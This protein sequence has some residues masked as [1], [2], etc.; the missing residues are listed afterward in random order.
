[1]FYLLKVSF[2]T[3][4]LLKLTFL[5]LNFK[6]SVFYPASYLRELMPRKEISMAKVKKPCYL[7]THFFWRLQVCD[8]HY[9][10]H[11]PWFSSMLSSSWVLKSYTVIIN[12]KTEMTRLFETKRACSDRSIWIF[13]NSAASWWPWRVKSWM[14]H[15]RKSKKKK[16]SAI[17]KS[18]KVTFLTTLKI[19]HSKP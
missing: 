15:Y 10:Y 17:E 1:M 18:D 9:R 2:D 6:E 11:T 14:F 19:V 3:V 12:F 5:N 16:K 13:L 4:T 7:W 8:F